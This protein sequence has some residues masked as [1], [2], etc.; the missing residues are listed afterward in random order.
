VI[1]QEYDMANETPTQGA[2]HNEVL[3]RVK[4]SSPPAQLAAAISH[5]VYDG[6]SVTLRAIGAGAVNQGV[7]AI[8]IAQGYVGQR[9][10]TLLV[11]P[12]F[13]TVQMPDRDVSAI[14]LKVFSS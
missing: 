14:V 9:G 4:N 8:A 12:G 6:K 1:H 11:R 3:L 5:A 7:K 13:Q 10:L 2:N